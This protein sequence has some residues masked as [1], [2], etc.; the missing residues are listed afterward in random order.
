MTATAVDTKSGLSFVAELAAAVGPDD[1]LH[2]AEDLLLYEYDGSVARRRP[3]AVVFPAS[4]QEV[5]E[6]V[7]IA[8]ARGIPVVARGAGTGLAG[9]CIP[10]KG[11]I[12]LSTAR[13]NR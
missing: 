3:D 1:V 2:R 13:M 8:R 4:T 11:G 10:L 7:N 5:V 6:V 12:V 9:G